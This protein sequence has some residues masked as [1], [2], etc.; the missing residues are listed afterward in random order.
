MAHKTVPLLWNAFYFMAWENRLPAKVR[1][2]AVELLKQT[3]DMNLRELRQEMVARNR[4]KPLVIGDIHAISVELQSGTY[5]DVVD[6][7]ITGYAARASLRFAG[8]AGLWRV[9]PHLHF[10][11]Q[12]AGCCQSNANS[13]LLAAM[14]VG[15]CRGSRGELPP[16]GKRRG[17]ALLVGLAIDEMAFEIE[18]I[19]DVGMDRGELL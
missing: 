13:S 17:A 19:V 15:G 5:S 12:F 14:G 8:T 9:M 16:L 1:R 7:P 18:V 2:Q 10:E 11:K 6:G 3:P 4:F